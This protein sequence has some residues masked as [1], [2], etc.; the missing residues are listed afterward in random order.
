MALDQK[1][2]ATVNLLIKADAQGSVE[3]LR[4]SLNKLSDEE[5]AVKIISSGVGAISESGVRLAATSN[6]SVLGFNVRADVQARKA[7]QADKVPILYYRIIYEL[8]EAV[9]KMI[10]GAAEPTIK[11]RIIG[12]AAVKDVF[13]SSKMGAVAGCEVHEGTIK[14]GC[15]IRVLRDNIVIYEGQLESL[16]RFKEDVNE[17]GFGSECGIAVKNYNDVKV[18]DN[19]EV[20]ERLEVEEKSPLPV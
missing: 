7:A 18:G 17:V 20:Y 13:R 2:A 9:Q 3:A 15:P 19:I 1:K 6:A 12:V 4:D 16:R 10:E 11:E 14:H 8:I 5:V